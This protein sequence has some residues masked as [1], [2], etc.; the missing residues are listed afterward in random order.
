MGIVKIVLLGALC[1]TGNAVQSRQTPTATP[2]APT[3]SLLPAPA[4]K[5]MSAL[6][7]RGTS[8][9]VATAPAEQHALS[10]MDADTW[11]DGYLP[12]ALNVADIPGAVV[13][14][15]K[16]G[17]ILTARGFGYAN[18]AKRT[19]VDPERTLFRPGSVSK[20]VT[21]TAVMQLVERNKLDLDVDVNRYLDFTIPP[22]AGVPVT[23]RQIMTHT[24][25]F[26]EAAKD[27]IT[28]APNPVPKLGEL[29]KTWVPRRI[30]DAGTTPAYS[31]Y[32]TA[33]AGYIVE[34]QSGLTFD[35]YVEQNIFKPLGMH[36]ASFRQPLPAALAAH[37]SRGYGKDG[38]ESEG[39]E[40]IGPAP[41]GSL[42]ASGT[43]MARFMIANL[44]QGAIDGQQ[45]L[46]PATAAAMHD[47]SLAKVNPLSLIAPLNRM[48]LGFFETN[49]NGRSVIGHLGDTEAFHTSLHLFMKEGVGFYVSFNSAGKAG[50]AGTLRTAI[51]HDF[52]DRYFP[53]AS[54]A[55][56]RVDAATSAEHVRMMSGL[57]QGSRRGESSFYSLFGLFGQVKIAADEHGN[58]TIPALLGR[59]GR[60]REWIEVAPFVWRDANGHD[61][62]AARL[63]DGKVV[64]WSM[65]F[66]SPF[67]MLD[68]VPAG[69]SAG[70]LVPVLYASLAVL[71]LTFLAWPVGWINR[72]KYK[73][74]LGSPQVSRRISFAT[75][76]VAGCSLAVLAGW[77]GV[78]VLFQVSISHATA[79]LD[80]WL[81]LLQILGAL[82]FA[83]SVVIS[84]RNV[85]LAF[86]DGRGWPRKVWSVL[87]LAAALVIVYVAARFGL[88]AFTVNY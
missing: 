82:I 81:W 12:Y 33:L 2:A 69:I 17:Q 41:A 16:D 8:A 52:A 20:L 32:A 21:W 11:L 74:T 36:T 88:L 57:W 71:L 25:G 10:K 18:A 42:S 14:V 77:A 61:R 76:V 62:L 56:G 50:D 39:F 40:I 22:R 86:K 72:R 24:A 43:D 58:L 34:R 35:N 48:E 68:R 55:D 60:P 45:I 30:F 3:S 13:V 29:L 37:M 85:Q 66:M 59:N 31:N 63:V 15:V 53:D 79:K 38:K 19:P 75:Q 64:R 23:L 44:Q 83:A 4:L 78:L 47:S 87:V 70:W 27:I 84:A 80:P 26:E 54:P 7:R 6:P 5:P 67:M 65:D 73:V 28:Y 1:L 46:S 51:F 49:T 9:A